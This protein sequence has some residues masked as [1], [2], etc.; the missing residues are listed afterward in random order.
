MTIEAIIDKVDA[1]KP[2]AF[3]NAQKFSWLNTLEG[4]IQTEIWL[5]PA[6]EIRQYTSYEAEKSTVPLVKAP[7]DELYVWYICAMVDLFN[8]E[9][10]RYQNTMQV[11]NSMAGD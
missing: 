2:N 8:G 1:L 7:Y 10:N 6:G 3:T 4:K 9:T 11:Y 5:V